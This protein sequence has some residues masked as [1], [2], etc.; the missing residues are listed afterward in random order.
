MAG[1]PDRVKGRLAGE[2]DGSR[3]E[4]D[5]V[6]TA[7]RSVHDHDGNEYSCPSEQVTVMEVVKRGMLVLG[8]MWG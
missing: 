2:F 6:S 3:V 4:T 5:R 8:E 7:S 1:V